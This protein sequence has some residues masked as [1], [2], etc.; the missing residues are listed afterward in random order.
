MAYRI[1]GAQSAE[2]I[3]IY[4]RLYRER[5]IFLGKEIDDQV[6]NDIIGVLLYLDSEDSSKPIYMYINSAGGSVV[7]GLAIYDTMQHINSPVVT[8][9]IGLAASMASFLLAS[10]ERGRRLALPNSRVMIHQAVGAAEG[11]AEDIRVEAQHILRIHEDLV[12]MFAAM[13]GQ[14]TETTRSDLQRDNFMSAS[15]AKD[16]G[17]VDEIIALEGK[18]PQSAAKSLSA[19]PAHVSNDH[20]SVSEI[21][22]RQLTD[23]DALLIHSQM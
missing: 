1:P 6:A 10:G 19:S 7:S 12:R 9:N 22:E 8:I 11:Q 20:A 21:T 17:L 23:R 14:D 4:S 3:D 2:W 16:Y 15:E 18:A 13:T 5:I